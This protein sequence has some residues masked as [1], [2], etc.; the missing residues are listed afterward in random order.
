MSMR[1]SRILRP[2]ARGRSDLPLHRAGARSSHNPGLIAGIPSECTK[3]NML[4]LFESTTCYLS[5]EP[6]AFSLSIRRLRLG[7]L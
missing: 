5:L 4:T 1:T 3:P 2:P 7:L 6:S